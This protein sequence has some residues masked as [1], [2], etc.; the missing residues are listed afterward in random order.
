ILADLFIYSKVPAMIADI[1]VDKA[2][3]TGLALV[4]LCILTGFISMFVENVATVLV[5]APLALD[6]AKKLKVSP[7]PILFSIAISSN[8]QGT[9]TLVGDPPSMIFAGFAGFSFN[10]FF[11]YNGKPSIFF[12][13]E[14]GAVASWIYLYFLF[15][16]YKRKEVAEP[17]EKP[18]SCVPT[19]L[20]TL[21]VVGLAVISFV[22]KGFTIKSGYFCLIMGVIGL[23]WF[24][25]FE[26]KD[27]K[28]VIGLIKRLDWETIVFLMGIFTV[29]GTISKVGILDDFASW[30]SKNLGTNVLL[31]FVV[32]TGFSMILSGFIDNVP[33]I[34]IMLPVAARL[35]EAMG[36]NAFLLY[37][38]L[39]VGSCLGGNITP[40]G[41]SAN[42]VSVGLLKKEGYH[43][44]FWDFVK[45]GLPFTLITTITASLVCWLIL[46]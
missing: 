3:N 40:F 27:R 19:I 30:L 36:T 46:G 20:L 28:E 35:A 22:E 9:A 24:I 14:A 18:T 13:V 32:I 26:K 7:V 5:V 12:I 43:T 17:V 39:L 6:I 33:Y 21:M 31:S 37:Y 15:R 45:I 38:G 34:I 10:D 23:L 16:K 8:L 44:K 1:I 42:L 11:F 25:I 4:L 29:I 41:A 2:P